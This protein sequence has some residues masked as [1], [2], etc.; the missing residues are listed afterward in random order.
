MQAYRA[1]VPD[2]TS[3]FTDRTAGYP[4]PK[5]ECGFRPNLTG[6]SGGYVMVM[7]KVNGPAVAVLVAANVNCM[8]AEAPAARVDGALF[9]SVTLYR[10]SRLQ[11]RNW[12]CPQF[13]KLSQKG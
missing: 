7:V 11:S 5:K 13:L 6:S 3:H 12:L 1:C 10:H 2:N 9:D 4:D 8:F